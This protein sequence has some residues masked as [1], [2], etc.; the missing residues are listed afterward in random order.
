MDEEEHDYS[1]GEGVSIGD[2]HDDVILVQLPDSLSVFSFLFKF[3]NLSGNI[4]N[5]ISNF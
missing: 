5:S 2:F 1:L 3:C 4:D